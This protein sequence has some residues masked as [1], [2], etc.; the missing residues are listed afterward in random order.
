M[1]KD[2][3]IILAWPEGMVS[4]AG[5]WYDKYFSTNGKYR[6]GHSALVLINSTT[7]KLHYF[8]FGR[9]HT[10][11]GFGR[12]R[13]AET[14]TD[15]SINQ[16]AEVSGSNI[17]NIQQILF[18]IYNNEACHGEG[19]LYAS[20][21]SKV[22]F[23]SAFNYAKNWQNK[24]AINYGPFVLN[25]TNC[26]RF[27][28]KTARKSVNSYFMKLRLRFPFC[29]SPSP[30]R[31]VSIGNKDYYIVEKNKCTKICRGIIKSYFSSIER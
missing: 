5:A 11:S 31:N 20:V 13:D 4:A 26:S 3:L 7:K 12:I 9:Y 18:E 15:V 25:G 22:N 14:D 21:V 8:D 16:L 23:N 28:A 29:I 17:T 10:P 27:V 24:G 6:V 30:K 1:Y 19:K 2:F